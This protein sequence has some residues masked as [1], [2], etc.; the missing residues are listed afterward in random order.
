MAFTPV[1]VSLPIAD[2]RTSH[3]FYR[4]LLGGREVARPGQSESVLSLGG[5]TDEGV[6]A[7]VDRARDA[8]AEN[9]T[10]PGAQP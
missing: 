9:I 3:A 6:D 10:E 4:R 1:V 8:G 7:V 2:R 5:D